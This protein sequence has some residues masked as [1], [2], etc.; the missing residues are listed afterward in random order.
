[1]TAKSYN[2]VSWVTLIISISLY[3]AALTQEC[4]CTSMACGGHWSGLSILCLGAIGGIMSI[5]G[6]TWYANPL[7][8]AAWSL[9]KKQPKKAV[10]FSSLATI[11]AAGFMLFTEITDITP[12]RTAYITEY[13]IGYWLWLASTVTMAA[14][15]MLVFITNRAF[16]PQASQTIVL[17]VDFNSRC[18]GGIRLKTKGAMPGRITWP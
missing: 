18:G 12:G 4:Y 11:T 8:W 16:L 17:K 6:L 10:V 3:L 14:G 13:R 15:S 2:L 1:M 7:L 5:A 9:L